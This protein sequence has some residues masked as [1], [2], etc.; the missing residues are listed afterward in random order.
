MN[1]I[2]LTMIV[3]DESHV[4]ERACRSAAPHITTYC[5]CDTGSTDNTKQIIKSIFDSLGIDGIIHD[6]KWT[7][8]FGINRT[9]SM[10]AARKH[11]KDKGWSWV[12]DADD[13]IVGDALPNEFWNI[14]SSALYVD[15]E[16]PGS[17]Y[18]RLQVFNNKFEWIYLDSRHERAV[19]NTEG[20]VITSIP[21]SIWHISRREGARSADPLKF[22]RDAH[23]I[24]T[25]DLVKDPNNPRSLYYLAQSYKSAGLMA[26]AKRAYKARV[27]VSGWNQ[28]RYVSY[29]ELIKLEPNLKKKI[30]LCW[31][32]IDID[33]SRLEAP[34]FVLQNARQ[35]KTYTQEV[36]WLGCFVTNRT[37]NSSMLYT[38]TSLYQ[39]QYD[40]ELSIIAYWTGNYK[41]G[42]D[43][44]IRAKIA[45]PKENIDR[46]NK[47]LKFSLDKLKA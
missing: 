19:S 34:F 14:T 18:H 11:T 27:K 21:N 20:G 10:E 30:Q 46:V 26:E 29:Y 4:I 16:E 45:C 36:F 41:A 47:N 37:A 6:H 15:I 17:R 42:A 31:K 44:A 28:E 38:F 9:L 1:P 8:D 32:A 2:C 43:A 33:R 39:W 23:A 22:V 12:L 5:I 40:D 7:D 13:S 35:S 25:K 24:K 3:K